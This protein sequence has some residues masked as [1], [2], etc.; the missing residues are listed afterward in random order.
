MPINDSD[1]ITIFGEDYVESVSEKNLVEKTNVHKLKF[2][3]WNKIK[4]II[5][6]SVTF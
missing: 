6:G 3:I 5:L 4:I 1:G 2:N